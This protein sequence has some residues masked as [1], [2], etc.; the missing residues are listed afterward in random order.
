[1][2]GTGVE[3]VVKKLRDVYGRVNKKTLKRWRNL[4]RRND[5]VVP[6]TRGK[7]RAERFEIALLS[8]LVYVSLIRQDT[9]GTATMLVA[10]NAM[11]A[12][13]L[14]AART[15]RLKESVAWKNDEAVQKIKFS[16]RWIRDFLQGHAFKK[17]RITTVHNRM[18]DETDVHASM[19]EIARV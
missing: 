16:N 7:E 6:E 10:A 18:P 15:R 1:M 12:Y 8:E 17:R 9:A 5:G 11:F 3:P 4:A 2:H 13:D 19:E 14:I